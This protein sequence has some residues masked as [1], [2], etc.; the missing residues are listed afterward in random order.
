[1]PQLYLTEAAGDKRVRPLGLERV[2]LRCGETCRVTDEQAER[3][4]P[5]NLADHD[6][7]PGHDE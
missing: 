6:R 4:S 3:Q 1:M 2:V 5:A 7:H